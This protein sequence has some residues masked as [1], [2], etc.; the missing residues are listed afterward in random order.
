MEDGGISSHARNAQ[1][2][3][4]GAAPNG[5]PGLAP[6]YT[7]A[8]VAEALRLTENYVLTR[9]RSGD[10]PHRKGP[11]N[12]PRFSAGDYQRILELMAVPEREQGP[13]R[14]SWAPQSRRRM[15]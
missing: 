3:P 11:R 10:W 7:A 12:S 15:T 13:A 5:P 2:N 6:T 1:M 9:A 8:E 14:V 4:A